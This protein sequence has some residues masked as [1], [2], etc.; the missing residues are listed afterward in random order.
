MV[1]SCVYQFFWAIKKKKNKNRS[2]RFDCACRAYTCL[3]IVT[4]IRRDR[5]DRFSENATK[6]EPQQYRAIAQHVITNCRQA[7]RCRTS[8]GHHN[9]NVYNRI[10]DY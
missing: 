3:L 2:P 4:R 9:Q 1:I 5:D 6:R 7:C 8:L 10:I